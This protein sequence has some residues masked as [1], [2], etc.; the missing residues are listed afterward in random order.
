MQIYTKVN[1]GVYK[2]GFSTQQSAYDA[3]VAGVHDTLLQLNNRLSSQ[4]FLLG[5]M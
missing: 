2:A 1:N 4:R 3:A 5:N